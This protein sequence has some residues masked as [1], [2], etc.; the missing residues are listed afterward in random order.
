M[1]PSPAALAQTHAEVFPH[2]PWSAAEFADLLAAGG[3]HFAGDAQ[4]FVL[5]RVVLDEAEILTVASH[6]SMR[7]KG[8]ARQALE[9]FESS[10]PDTVKAIFLEVAEDNIAAI[11]LYRTQG[12]AEVGRRPGY[13]NS[14][15]GPAKTALIFSKSIPER[16]SF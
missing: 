11:S 5:G 4:T 10:L 8:H 2:R 13:Y 3:A 6:P 9:T 16:T 15:C 7:R 14:G 12:F 1:I